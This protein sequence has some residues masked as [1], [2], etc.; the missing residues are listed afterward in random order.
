MFGSSLSGASDIIYLK[1]RGQGDWGLGRALQESKLYSLALSPPLFM[2]YD[3][4]CSFVQLPG[5]N[6]TPNHSTLMN[7]LKIST[8]FLY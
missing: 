1:G 5:A 3:K 6:P 7:V 2:L 4:I 8:I